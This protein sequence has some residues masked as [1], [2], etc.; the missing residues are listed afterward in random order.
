MNKVK[1]IIKINKRTYSAITNNKGIATFK[2]TKLA[3]TGKYTALVK[4]AGNK[5]YNVK[6]VKVKVTVK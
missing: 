5:Y 4:F 3:K 1:L 2:I 6:S